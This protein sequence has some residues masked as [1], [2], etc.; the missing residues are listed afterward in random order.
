MLLYGII[1]KMKRLKTN[2]NYIYMCAL[3]I[4]RLFTIIANRGA[5]KG[6]DKQ[7]RGHGFSNKNRRKCFRFRKKLLPSAIIATHCSTCCCVNYAWAM[8]C[9]KSKW[10]LDILFCECAQEFKSFKGFSFFIRFIWVL[11]DISS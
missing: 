10:A 9:C 8:F 4:K 2:L 6:S 1:I 3:L 11:Y 7:R 5:Q